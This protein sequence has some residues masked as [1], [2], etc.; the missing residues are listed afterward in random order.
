MFCQKMT[1]VLE[2]YIVRG[3]RFVNDKRETAQD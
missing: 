2:F 3:L 1:K